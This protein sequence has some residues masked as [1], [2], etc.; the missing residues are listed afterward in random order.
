M[1]LAVV[2]LAVQELPEFEGLRATGREFFTLSLLI[3]EMSTEFEGWRSLVAG[4]VRGPALALHYWPP[5]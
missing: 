2:L 1:L 5:G 4:G 3:R